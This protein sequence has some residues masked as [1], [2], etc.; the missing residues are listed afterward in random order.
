M[1]RML[2][3]I[4]ASVVA[5]TMLGFGITSSAE[6]QINSKQRQEI[7]R[8][9][10]I[11]DRAAKQYQSRRF[12]EAGTTVAEAYLKLQELVEEPTAELIELVTPE[13]DRIKQA[14]QL[15][16]D[17]G[18]P[19]DPVADLPR[20]PMDP[21]A[22]SFVSDVAPILVAKCGRCHVDRVSGRFS[23]AN[24]QAIAEGRGISPQRP[25]ASRLIEVIESGEMPQGG[26]QVDDAELRILKDWIAAGAKFDGDDVAAGLQSFATPNSPNRREIEVM[27]ATGNETIS[28]SLHVA[29]VLIENCSGCHIESQNVRGGL[30]MTNFRGLLAG[31]DSGVIVN[32]GSDSESL[33]VQKLKGMGGGPRMPLNRP[34]LSDDQIATISKWI[35]E[36]AKFDGR[37]ARLNI[38]NVAALART[39]AMDH[40]ELTIDRV[41]SS[42]DNWKLVMSDIEP[43]HFETDSFFALGSASDDRLKQ[44]AELAEEIAVKVKPELYLD[45]NA[46]IVKGRM[47]LFLFQRRYDYSEFGKMIESRDLPTHFTSHWGHDTINAYAAILTNPREPFDE[48]QVRADL[49]R[50]IAATSIRDQAVDVPRWFADGVGYNV[51]KRL[52]NKDDSVRSWDH[53]AAA[54]LSSMNRPDDF[55]Q[56]RMTEDNAAL[57]SYLFVGSLM[58]DRGKYSKFM[59]DIFQQQSFET[60]F[61]NAYSATPAEL[62]AAFYGT[63]SNRDRPRQNR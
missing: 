21:D 15:L 5:M 25:E 39:E 58:K 59:K 48:E 10:V 55:L 30:N 36:G 41:K 50:Q 27:P 52:F 53:A 13:Y 34:A 20:P 3:K 28:F 44:F 26:L 38:R 18:Q 7:K 43:N 37:D 6:G 11:V 32:P 23:L 17:Q 29:P 46:P 51:A 31:G 33:L 63:G 16:R 47:T 24:Y 4:V 57:V 62:I 49:A 60:A 56:N 14:Y 8:I 19:M 40:A 61:A 45:R 54:A 12:D 9:K 42:N 35:T 2:L 22:I 1:A